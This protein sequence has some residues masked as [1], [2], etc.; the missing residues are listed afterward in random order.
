MT[1][2]EKRQV[3]I[4]IAGRK[5]SGYPTVSHT[6]RF[7]TTEEFMKITDSLIDET[8]YGKVDVYIEDERVFTS[9]EVDLLEREFFIFM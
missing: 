1:T 7:S 5:I 3:D 6:V 2:P 4:K 8:G 9:E